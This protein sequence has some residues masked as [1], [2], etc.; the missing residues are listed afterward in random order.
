[1]S[2]SFQ[3][4]RAYRGIHIQEYKSEKI[5]QPKI[6]ELTLE[7]QSGLSKQRHKYG[8]CGQILSVWTFWW[9]QMQLRWRLVL[10][11]I[12][13]HKER[14]VPDLKSTLRKKKASLSI[15]YQVFLA[16]QY[17]LGPVLG[18]GNTMIIRTQKLPL[19]IWKSGER[20]RHF[21]GIH[22]TVS[23]GRQVHCCNLQLENPT[24][25]LKKTQ[26]AVRESFLEKVTPS[27]VIKC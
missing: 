26:V 14:V 6:K 15:I 7:W 11:I 12:Y 2:L 22:H 13:Y 8:L 24:Q 1:M 21:S 4:I 25:I 23:V 16:A 19:L 9:L 3:V 27:W 18:S 17:I 10:T 20:D 5:K